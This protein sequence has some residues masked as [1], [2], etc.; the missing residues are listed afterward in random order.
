MHQHHLPHQRGAL[1]PASID[2]DIVGIEIS[3]TETSNKSALP[4]CEPELIFVGS[5]SFLLALV[6]CV[7]L[8]VVTSSASAFKAASISVEEMWEVFFFLFSGSILSGSL[9]DMSGSKPYL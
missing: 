9:S 6:L 3:E 4:S 8:G 2:S 5:T 1:N 7:D